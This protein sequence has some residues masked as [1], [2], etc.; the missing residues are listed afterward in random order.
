MLINTF[1]AQIIGIDPDLH[2]CMHFIE[3]DNI[4]SLVR[5]KLEDYFK[6]KCRKE[7]GN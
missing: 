1:V 7:I 3:K 6:E 2:G 5:N 4:I